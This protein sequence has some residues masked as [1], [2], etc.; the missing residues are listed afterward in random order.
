[1]KAGR[2]IAAPLFS[3]KKICQLWSGGFD[4][5]HWQRASYTDASFA[6]SVILGGLATRRYD[7]RQ[8]GTVAQLVEPPTNN[9]RVAGSSPACPKNLKKGWWQRCLILERTMTGTAGVIKTSEPV[10]S[11]RSLC[12]FLWLR[13]HSPPC[14]RS[15]K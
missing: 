3:C 15:T 10:A 2:P 11:R 1:M 9:R 7:V 14:G 6:Q 12:R 13:P 5:L 8:Y 4:S